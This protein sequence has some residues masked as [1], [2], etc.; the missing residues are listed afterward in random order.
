VSTNQE[1]LRILE[2]NVVHARIEINTNSQFPQRGQIW[3]ANLGQNIG[4]EMNGKNN[5]FE[6]P[7]LVIK[8]LNADSVFVA[9]ITSTISDRNHLIKF[10]L[11][12]N[13]MSVNIFQLRTLSTKRFTKKI[14][15]ICD[16]DFKRVVEAIE[17]T[18]L[19]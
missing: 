14:S 9:P 16:H 7:V 11:N 10:D 15:D 8:N 19:N 1:L 12:T 17:I 5:N 6:R 3:W 18:I 2:W 4:V 13:K